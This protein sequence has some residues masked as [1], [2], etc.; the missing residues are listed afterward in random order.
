MANK[1]ELSFT[2]RFVT[3]DDKVVYKTATT[4]KEI[5]QSI[6]DMSEQLDNTDLGSDTWKEYNKDLDNAKKALDQV[7]QSQMSLGEKLSAIP[8]PVGA[9]VQ[10][11]RGIG[12]AFKTIQ[13]AMGPFGLLLTAIVGT[14]GVLAK[15]FFSTKEGGEKL[16]QITAG[17][18]AV[19]DVF[20]DVLVRIGKSLVGLF[21]DPV[22]SL[23]NFGKALVDN[24]VNRFVGMLELIP[25]IGKAIGLL[26]K[27]EFAEAGKVATNAIGKVVLGVEDTVGTIGKIADEVGK[28]VSESVNEG[29][30]A[31]QITAGLQKLADA[32]RQLNKD[33]ATGNRI[34]SE[35][36]L[37]AVDE[38]K[39]FEERI[40]AL[41]KAGKLEQELADRQAKLSK[42]KY[43][44]LVAQNALSDSSAEALDAEIAAW[45]EYQNAL[46][47]SANVRREL[48]SQNK[49]LRDRAAAEQKA[50]AD[51]IDKLRKEFADNAVEIERDRLQR[52]A[53]LRY[54][55]QI[56]QIDALKITEEEKNKLKE[57][58]LN[59]WNKKRDQINKDQDA[60]D[61][62]AAR[63]KAIKEFDERLKIE[64][65]NLE[66]SIEG[67]LEAFDI[68]RGILETNMQKELLMYEGNEKAQTAIKDKYSKLRNEIDRAEQRAKLAAYNAVLGAIA[69]LAG[70]ETAI[71][72]AA[73]IA[74][75]SI[76]T[77][78]AAS[79]I[80]NKI[81]GTLPPPVG[82]ILGGIAA[83]ITVA[84]G[85]KQGLKIAGINTDLP[86]P[87]EQKLNAGGIVGGI[88][89][90]D[91]VSTLLT[92]G[93]SVMNARS[94]SMFGPLLS[95]LN[96][97]GGGA[98]FT[99][100]NNSDIT[101][102]AQLSMMG[103]LVDSMA[104][105]I[106][107]YVVSTDITNAQEFNRRV[108]S[109]ST[110]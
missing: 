38:T 107:T 80:F 22:Q 52:E 12:T 101:S 103:N 15:A 54:N 91:S 82:Q 1:E 32:Q 39:S 92:P 45:T 102:Q 56:A 104:G 75:N 10:S 77:Y 40:D 67:S 47:S 69:S 44:L 23:K 19:M 110:I 96:Q 61:L 53:E 76:N 4:L 94:T 37:L 95:T 25:N 13:A 87:Q 64:Q 63:D 14:L 28:I 30:K 72:K 27:G 24:V 2:L 78:L 65:L 36:K 16:Q 51:T 99:G 20:R 84:A 3:P 70:E 17:L 89:A 68:Q 49:A 9:A 71:G 66:A 93:E 86:K 55:D 62:Q 59:S 50:I 73:A 8:G 60:K 33:R 34:I 7:E 21:D 29:K 85:V 48:E 98:R 81:Q 57:E 41:N 106:K 6:K 35:A 97:I 100:V 18:N 79:D 43:D 109:R 26:F 46:T 108:E 90:G 42:Q 88:G 31:A 105:P 5:N 74:Q 58:A 11:L 83:A